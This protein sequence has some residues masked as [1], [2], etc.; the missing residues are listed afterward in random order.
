MH[1]GECFETETFT[2]ST[3]KSTSRKSKIF[4]LEALVSSRPVKGDC[5]FIETSQIE[6]DY[7]HDIFRSNS[8]FSIFEF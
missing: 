3:Q 2:F 6:N 7:H 5:S 1:E 8:E 4:A